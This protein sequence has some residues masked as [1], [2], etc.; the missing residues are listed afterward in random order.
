MYIDGIQTPGSFANV[1]VVA[2]SGSRVRL[3]R[4]IA[5]RLARAIFVAIIIVVVI[6]MLMIHFFNLWAPEL[7]PLERF[8]YYEYVRF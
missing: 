5:R 4:Y 7:F 2:S 3:G 1:P 6:P 8:H